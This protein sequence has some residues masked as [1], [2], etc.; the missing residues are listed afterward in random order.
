MRLRTIAATA[1]RRRLSCRFFVVTFETE[2]RNPSIPSLSGRVPSLQPLQALAQ[3]TSSL[4]RI[5]WVDIAPYS[6]QSIVSLVL[7]FA[8]LQEH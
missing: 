3:A 8:E 6:L 5:A 4:C 7:G 1:G 2:L